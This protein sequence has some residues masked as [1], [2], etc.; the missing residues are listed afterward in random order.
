MSANRSHQL[1]TVGAVVILLA[2][3][4]LS[5]RTLGAY[6]AHVR[7][8]DQKTSTLAELQRLKQTAGSDRALAAFA[9][10][11]SKR[12]ADLTQLVAGIPALKR[13]DVRLKERRPL[14]SGWTLL[15]ADLSFKEILLSDLGRF[16]ESAEQQRP[17]WRLAECVITATDRRAGTGNATLLM[18]ALEQQDSATP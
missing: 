8:L 10:L 5:V 7:H 16:I 2:G 3:V 12:A 14:E 15:R 18:E 11:P 17:P 1:L 9:Q 13:P 4:A 6:P